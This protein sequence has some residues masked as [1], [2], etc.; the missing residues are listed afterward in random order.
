MYGVVVRYSD[1]SGNKIAED[2]MDILASGML[3]RE[4]PK[5]VQETWVKSPSGWVRRQS[6]EA[7]VARDPLSRP[8][9]FSVAL[10][11]TD[12][13]GRRWQ[14]NRDGSLSRDEKYV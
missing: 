11:F 14:R 2:S 3:Q 7:V 4:L 12:A 5:S 13:A 10:E 8:W 9:E 1:A 6:P